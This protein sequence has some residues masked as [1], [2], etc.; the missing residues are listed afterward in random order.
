MHVNQHSPRYASQLHLD[1]GIARLIMLRPRFSGKRCRCAAPRHLRQSWTAA[2]HTM[3]DSPMRTHS[4][5]CLQPSH[6]YRDC[7]KPSDSP[8]SQVVWPAALA[9][10]TTISACAH[11][12]RT[13]FRGQCRLKQFGPQNYPR[14]YSGT[15]KCPEVPIDTLMQQNQRRAAPRRQTR[16]ACARARHAPGRRRPGS[17]SG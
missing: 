3:Q 12:P 11:A 14:T 8:C 5:M 17:A 1:T 13:A 15:L 10:G 16:P 2:C 6:G 9:T 7:S 4:M